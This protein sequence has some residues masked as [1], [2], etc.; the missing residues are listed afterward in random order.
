MPRGA[1]RFGGGRPISTVRPFVL[2]MPSPRPRSAADAP[3][4]QPLWRRGV[5]LLVRVLQA[6]FVRQLRL[7]R[8]GG[9]IAVALEDKTGPAP[10]AG[11]QAGADGIATDPMRSELTA[12][13][14]AAPGSRALL[15]VLAAVEHGLK[16]KDASGLFL[17]EV[18]GARLRTALRQLDG[19]AP[20]QPAPGLAALRE[21]IA[22]AIGVHE[23]RERRLEMLMPRSDLMQGN[24]VEVGEAR[25]S[26]FDR[27]AEQWRTQDQRG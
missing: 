12:L 6:L 25:P 4:V 27:A 24:R 11:A 26:D 18:D 9:R 20:P 13:F 5:R 2:A 16:H 22:D 1:L 15:R 3:T 21:R 23:Q 7:R 19:L 8:V 14:D 17:F 10:A